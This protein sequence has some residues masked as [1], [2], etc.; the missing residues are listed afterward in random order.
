MPERSLAQALGLDERYLPLVRQAL[1]HPSYAHE[2]GLAES[3]QRLEFLGDAVLQLIISD[4]LHRRYSELPEGQLSR[5]RAAVVCE[6]AL[7][8]AALRIEL[9]RYM[10]L[11]R[12]EES[13]GGRER[14]SV[15]ADAC[16]ALLGAVYRTGGLEPAR[17]LA[18]RLLAA[19]LSALDPAAAVDYKTMLQEHVQR[20]ELGPLQ[21]EVIDESGPD[22]DK[23]FAVAVL[24]AGRELAR[25]SGRSKK[26]AQ[27][28]AAK[29]A[30]GRLTAAVPGQEPPPAE[31]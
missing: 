1:T 22:H 23:R 3:N 4:E 26:Q 20:Y 19:E 2:H 21:Y 28:E 24:L 15:L 17:Q 13:S 31:R 7:T 27:L 12:G 25:G 30:L 5:L 16:E 9:G 18:L 10:L 8:R 6:A 14:P 11:G 29:D